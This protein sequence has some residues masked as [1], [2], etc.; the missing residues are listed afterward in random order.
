[1][2]TT[3]DRNAQLLSRFQPGTS[4]SLAVV[5]SQVR[6]P[7]GK[8]GLERLFART[9]HSCLF[10]ND[11]GSYWYLGQERAIDKAIEAALSQ[12]QPSRIIHYGSSMGG[13]GA[14]TSGLRRKDGTIHA[15][16][17]ELCPGRPG[18][19]STCNGVKAHD[20]RLFDFAGQETPFPVHLYFGCLD[21]VDA[22][23]AGF[24]AALLPDANLHLLV[25]SHASHDH[26][27]SLNLIRRIINT[28]D[29]APAAELA[30]KHLLSSDSIAELSAFGA[31][32]EAI[33][34]GRDVKP[35]RIQE[36]P[37]LSRN[38]GMLRLLA[39]SLW[40]H[41]ER[42]IALET[43][44]QAEQLIEADAVLKTLPKRWRK[45][46]PLQ[47]TAWLIE[48]GRTEEARALL[49]HCADSFPV[50]A[51]MLHL[52]EQL[53]LELPGRDGDDTQSR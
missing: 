11:T 2:D 9:R 6:V 19:Q 8:F 12:A 5:Y 45:E 33:A 27:Y 4:G 17:T 24:A 28:F 39:A 38:P 16:G 22:A 29:R 42:D 13:Y 23:N 7:A 3:P 47:R 50:D 34:E 43:L 37:A 46:L 36:L 41:Q 26:L 48:L 51:H 20:P 53:G 30:S 10:L 15:F 25:S 21:P 49:K 14:L 40:H 1:M 35:H 44:R 52:A 32:A 31:L 18:Y